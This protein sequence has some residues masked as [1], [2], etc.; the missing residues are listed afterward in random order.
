MA[1]LITS[2]YKFEFRQVLKTGFT[3]DL[4]KDI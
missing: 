4:E 3:L 1:L 2:E